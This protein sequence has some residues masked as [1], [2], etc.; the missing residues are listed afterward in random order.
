MLLIA[1][2]VWKYGGRD[3]RTPEQLKGDSVSNKLKV[4]TD[5]WSNLLTSTKTL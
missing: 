1:V 3:R 4:R 5:M 2:M